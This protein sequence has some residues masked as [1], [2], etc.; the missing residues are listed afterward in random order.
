[1]KKQ[2]FFTAKAAK[3]WTWDVPKIILRSYACRV[4]RCGYCL[5]VIRVHRRSSAASIIR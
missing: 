1:M 5:D 4:L 2:R 3:K